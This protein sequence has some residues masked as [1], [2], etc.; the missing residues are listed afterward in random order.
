MAVSPTDSAT[1]RRF[2]Q[3]SGFK[4]VSINPQCVHFNL[5]ILKSGLPSGLTSFLTDFRGQRIILK[6][7]LVPATAPVRIVDVKEEI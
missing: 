1:I 6:S 5:M 3:T 2:L 4:S 7:G